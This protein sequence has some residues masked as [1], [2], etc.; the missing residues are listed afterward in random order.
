MVRSKFKVQ[1][2]HRRARMVLTIDSCKASALPDRLAFAVQGH[3]HATRLCPNLI[4]ARLQDCQTTRLPGAINFYVR[5]H[6]S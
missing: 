6:A 4:S 1:G 2:A 3:A 5:W